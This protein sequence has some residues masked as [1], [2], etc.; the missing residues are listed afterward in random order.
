MI[1]IQRKLFFLFFVITVFSGCGSDVDPGNIEGP[2]RSSEAIFQ[3][4]LKFFQTKESLFGDDSGDKSQTDGRFHSNDSRLR[5]LFCHQRE[6]QLRNHYQCEDN[7][8]PAVLFCPS[9]STPSF[10]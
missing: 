5:D 7:E 10:R 8:K 3:Q 2:P 1:P 6:K 9:D 4:D